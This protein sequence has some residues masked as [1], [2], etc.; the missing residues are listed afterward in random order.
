[1]FDLF[2]ARARQLKME[3]PMGKF[4]KMHIFA[5][6]GQFLMILKQ[7]LIFQI[8]SL[9]FKALWKVPAME[10]NFQLIPIIISAS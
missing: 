6:F 8:K 4:E 10:G 7:I 1:M 9:V 2:S 5:H 3:N